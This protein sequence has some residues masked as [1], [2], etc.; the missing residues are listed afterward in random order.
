MQGAGLKL[1]KIWGA[2]ALRVASLA[3]IILAPSASEV[4]MSCSFACLTYRSRDSD[5]L[6]AAH[7]AALSVDGIGAAEVD[8]AVPQFSKPR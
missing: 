2:R 7:L 3:K 6:P 4:I 5:R 1:R 8:E